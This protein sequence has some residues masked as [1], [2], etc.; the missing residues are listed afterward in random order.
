MTLIE[1]GISYA[2]FF[3]LNNVI[4]EYGAREEI[5]KNLKTLTVHQRF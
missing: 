5:I 2:E 3:S 1:P 4:G